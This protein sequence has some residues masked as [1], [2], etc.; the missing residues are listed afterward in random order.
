MARIVGSFHGGPD[1]APASFLGFGLPAPWCQRWPLRD[2]SFDL[3]TPLL[4]SSEKT[5]TLCFS[6]KAMIISDL[7]THH[8]FLDS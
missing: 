1:C 8:L 5:K 2:S 3:V 7:F 6:L 4:P